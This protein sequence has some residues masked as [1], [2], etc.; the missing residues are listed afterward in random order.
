[1]ELLTF[2]KTLHLA[3]KSADSVRSYINGGEM[4]D[5]LSAIGD[6]HFLAAKRSLLDQGRSKIPDRE[7]SMAITQ[8]RVGY[9]AFINGTNSK[10]LRKGYQASCLI[11]ICY[12]YLGEKDLA[13]DWVKEC[14]SAFTKYEERRE[15][16]WSL[17]EQR[18]PVI[19][20]S[21]DAKNAGLA[22]LLADVWKL[23]ERG[24]K[25]FAPEKH[26]PS[27]LEE[28]KKAHKLFLTKYKDMD[29]S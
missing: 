19:R 22:I 15:W 27:V 16:E 29:S 10:N 11:L 8:L 18:S 9:E 21:L 4:A 12:R 2:I 25:S 14:K 7:V 3:V 24:I 26:T 23:I 17:M 6:S 5:M 20:D 13:E 1:M 28:E